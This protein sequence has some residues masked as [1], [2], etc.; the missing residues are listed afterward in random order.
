MQAH[1]DAELTQRLAQILHAGLQW[2]T[3]PETRAEFGIHPVGAGV[4][5]DHQQFPHAGAH[6]AL[7]LAHDV[8]DGAADQV[9]AHGGNDAE[10]AAVVAALGNLQVGIVAGRQLDPLRRHQVREWIVYPGVRHILVH[11]AHHLL[12]GGGAGHAQH[13]G[14][15]FHD[16][17]GVIPLAHAAGHDHPAIFADGLTDG[18]QG[19]LLGTVDKAAGVHHHDLRI[20]V[21]RHD[22]VAVHLQ[23]GE[24]TFRIH[25]GLGAAEAD[26]TD[27]V[28]GHY[29]YRTWARLTGSWGKGGGLYLGG[30]GP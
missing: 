16:G 8:A 5:G 6:Q 24:D 22:L 9:P 12:I 15:Q 2:T 7:R 13:L 3:L 11:R 18:V 1:P 10:A 23:L 27:F 14:V 29:R 21:A 30:A 17:A 28:T 26:E 19:L 4:L 25:Q 20:L